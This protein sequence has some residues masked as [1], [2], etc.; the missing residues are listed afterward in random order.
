[1]PLVLAGL[2]VVHDHTMVAVTIGDKDFVGRLVDKCLSRQS[3]VLH[4]VAAFALVRMTD[5][6][7]ERAVLRELQDHVIVEAASSGHLRLVGGPLRAPA[8][9]ANPHVALIV[10]GDSVV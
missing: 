6:H 8:V 3:E 10:D 4:V 2:R 7:Q 9:A 5:L 1:M